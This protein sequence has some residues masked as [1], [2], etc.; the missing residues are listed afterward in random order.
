MWSRPILEREWW[1]LEPKLPT[2]RTDSP[3]GGETIRDLRPQDA[4]A[5]RYAAERAKE[6][7]LV[8]SGSGQVLGVR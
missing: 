1:I 6:G 2:V 4:T 8:R 7:I 3:A 5:A